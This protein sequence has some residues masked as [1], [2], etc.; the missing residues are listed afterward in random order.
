MDYGAYASLAPDIG[1]DSQQIQNLSE[2]GRARIAAENAAKEAKRKEKQEERARHKGWKGKM[3]QGL[4]LVRGM[5]RK[6]EKGQ[7]GGGEQE[8]EKM[9]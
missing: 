8:F 6:K 2:E 9:G 5:L 4:E 7:G 1:L 3:E